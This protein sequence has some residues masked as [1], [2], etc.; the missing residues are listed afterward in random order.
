[1]VYKWKA[2]A[3][4]RGSA[5]DIGEE[6]ER[7]KQRDA[8]GVLKVARRSKGAIHN[9]VFDR[10]TENAAEAYYLNRAGYLLRTLV[11]VH[12]VDTPEGEKATIE[13]RAYEAVHLPQDD[14]DPEK[15]MTYVPT[16]EALSDPDLRAQVMNRLDSVIAEAERTANAYTY[17]VPGLKRTSEK[18]HEARETV[19]A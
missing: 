8:P 2:G 14:D 12:E 16:Q 9:F 18:L 4:V 11:A 17:L 15:P 6:L 10:D 1:M 7:V 19:R 13:V 5:Q 3:R